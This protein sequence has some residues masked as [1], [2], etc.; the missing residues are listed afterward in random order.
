MENKRIKWSKQ[1]IYI[2]KF[3]TRFFEN[4]RKLKAYQDYL[5]KKQKFSNNI[6]GC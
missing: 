5:Q 1:I 2:E 6:A 4:S 3:A